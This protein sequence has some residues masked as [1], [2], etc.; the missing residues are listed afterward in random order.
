MKSND[1]TFTSSSCSRPRMQEFT[2]GRFGCSL[3]QRLQGI[4]DVK[5]FLIALA[6]ILSVSTIAAAQ[7]TSPTQDVLGAHNVYGRG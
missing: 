2:A 3:L 7:V 6:V 1:P 5:Q 4:S